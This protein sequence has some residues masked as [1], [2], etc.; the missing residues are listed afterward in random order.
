MPTVFPTSV[1]LGKVCA[2]A[3]N[4]TTITGDPNGVVSGNKYDIVIQEPGD[5]SRF[6]WIKT[7]DGGNTGWV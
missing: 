7:T 6:I 2:G 3:K 1:L 5:G 4:I